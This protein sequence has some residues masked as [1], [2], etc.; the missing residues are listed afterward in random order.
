MTGTNY[1]ITWMYSPSEE[2]DIAH[3]QTGKSSLQSTQNLYWR[4]VFC[5]FESSH[6]NNK[7]TFK[8]LLYVNKMPPDTIDGIST[9][10]LIRAFNIDLRIIDERSLPPKGYYKA[11]SSQ[12]LLIDVIRQMKDLITADDRIVLLDSDVIFT[13]PVES[14]FFTDIDKY[15]SLLYT[16]DYPA[17]RQVNGLSL[18]ELRSMVSEFSSGDVSTLR[19]EGGEIICFKGSILSQLLDTLIMGYRWSRNRHEKGLSKFNTE[20]HLF[21]FAYWKLG[22]QTFTANK[23]IKRMWTDLSSTVNLEKGD[24]N[25]LLWHLPAEKKHGFIR[26][27]RLMGRNGNTMAGHENDL[28]SIFRVRPTM[29]DRLV[30]MARIPLKKTYKLLK[31]IC[32]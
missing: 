14:D 29:R 20:E 12:F 25:R 8:H 31:A 16:I 3:L 1:L 4:C 2:Q 6:R 11:W 30:M 23:Y 32:L 13:R 10:D 15:N 21:S 22:L 24:E 5:L 26:Y 9:A 7:S 17:H 19:A 28:A 27:F 18:N